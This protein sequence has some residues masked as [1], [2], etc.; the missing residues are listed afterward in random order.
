MTQILIFLNP[1]SKICSMQIFLKPVGGE[2]NKMQGMTFWTK[3]LCF[4]Y[5]VLLLEYGY[6]TFSSGP[7]RLGWLLN[8]VNTT[9]PKIGSPDQS[10]LECFFVE[11][12]GN[13]FKSTMIYRYSIFISLTLSPY[14]YIATKKNREK[15]VAGFLERKYR[16][17]LSEVI[18][19][20]KLDLDKI[21]HIVG[22]YFFMLI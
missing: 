11:Q 17:Q 14:F 4:K 7:K 12:N 18:I 6:E 10:G 22:E 3:V 21:E 20:E 9:V 1:I 2:S 19:I 13:L 8:L 5:S 16:Q 15:L